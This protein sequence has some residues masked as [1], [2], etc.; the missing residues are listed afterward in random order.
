MLALSNSHLLGDVPLWC[1]A[2]SLYL[3]PDT[4]SSLPF[5]LIL[6][7]KRLSLLTCCKVQYN[8]A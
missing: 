4:H 3:I 2:G 1:V 5:K 7:W 8:S 6:H